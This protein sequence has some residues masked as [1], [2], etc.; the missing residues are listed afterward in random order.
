MLSSEARLVLLLLFVPSL[1]LSCTNELV[2]EGKVRICALM[3]E[4]LRRLSDATYFLEARCAN[5]RNVFISRSLFGAG[6]SLGRKDPF[7]DVI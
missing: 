4:K 5:C 2:I 6:F 3:A 1:E 7:S